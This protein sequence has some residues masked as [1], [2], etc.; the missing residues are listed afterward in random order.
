MSLLTQASSPL[1][2]EAPKLERIYETAREITRSLDQIV[3]AVNPQYDSLESFVGYL[4]DFAQP[5]LGLARVRCRLDI[6]AVLPPIVLSGETRHQ[7]FLCCREALNNVVKHAR[8]TEVT[9]R[10]AWTAPRLRIVIADDGRGLAAAAADTPERGRSGHGLANL[11]E[12]MA[13]L[14][15]SGTVGP[16]A[17]GGTVV[18][19]VVALAGDGTLSP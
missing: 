7:L 2:P 6:P 13:R 3:W 5:F 15:G 9:V 10:L 14:G 18:T 12:R 11:R 1:S 8:A 19:L 17:E 16:A 4:T